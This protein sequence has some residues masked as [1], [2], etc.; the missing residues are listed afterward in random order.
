LGDESRGRPLSVNGPKRSGIPLCN[1]GDSTNATIFL[2][3]AVG[4]HKFLHGIVVFILGFGWRGIVSY[5]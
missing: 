2:L 3:V 5:T 1:L 4:I